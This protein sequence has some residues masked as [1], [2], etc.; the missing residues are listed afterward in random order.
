MNLLHQSFEH[1]PQENIADDLTQ[2]I[3]LVTRQDIYVQ[4]DDDQEI[5]LLK[6]GQE[7]QEDMLRKLIQCGA[8]PRQFEFQEPGQ[9]KTFILP[10]SK[11]SRHSAP[12][13]LSETGGSLSIK[14]VS[15]NEMAFHQSLVPKI[16]IADTSDRGIKRLTGCLTAC[17]VFLHQI[18]PVT[19]FKALAWAVQKYRPQILIVDGDVRPQKRKQQ[20]VDGLDFLL[21]LKISHQPSQTILLLNAS[22][23]SDPEKVHLKGEAKENGIHIIFKPVTRFTLQAVFQELQDGSALAE[24]SK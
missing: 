13:A 2:G 6:A 21:N 15:N 5:L 3:R 11:V 8:D 24:E 1:T 17:G 16:M 22:G 7:V 14:Q 18:H 10:G 4:R 12:I 19:N 23:L 20:A 9:T